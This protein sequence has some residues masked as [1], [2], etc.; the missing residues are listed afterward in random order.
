MLKSSNA[1]NLKIKR[2]RRKLRIKS[3]RKRIRGS[4]AFMIPIISNRALSLRKMME[5]LTKRGNVTPMATNQQN[6]I[7]TYYTVSMKKRG[8]QKSLLSVITRPW[9]G[10]GKMSRARKRS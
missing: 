9:N 6:K 2:M 10:I 4:D 5:K 1:M 8:K 3:F 7:M